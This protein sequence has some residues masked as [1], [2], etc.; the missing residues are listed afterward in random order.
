MINKILALGYT[1]A[2][3]SL[4]RGFFVA[5]EYT[6]TGI[7]LFSIG[8]DINA[9]TKWYYRTV[10]GAKC[11]GNAYPL[12]LAECELVAEIS[13]AYQKYLKEVRDVSV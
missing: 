8:L 5:E 4:D 9:V 12:T 10:D 3:G 11:G 13:K 7:I 6:A 2:K 1:N